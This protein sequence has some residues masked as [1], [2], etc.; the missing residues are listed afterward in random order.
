[1][2][3]TQQTITHTAHAF[4]A[5]WNEHATLQFGEAALAFIETMQAGELPTVY[6]AERLGEYRD[7]FTR[8]RRTI[9]VFEQRYSDMLRDTATILEARAALLRAQQ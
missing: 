9:D 4:Q 6:L 1:M 8:L 5:F 7:A 3:T 2:S